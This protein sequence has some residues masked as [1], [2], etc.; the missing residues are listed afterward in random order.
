[1]LKRSSLLVPAILVVQAALALWAGSGEYLPPAPD[2]DHFPAEFGGWK[3][4]AGNADLAYVIG[5]LHS[6]RTMGWTYAQASTNATA[7]LFSAWFQSQRN[8]AAQPHSPQVCLPGNG[9]TMDTPSEI[10][11]STPAGV[12]PITRLIASKGAQRSLVW[13]WYETARRSVAGEWE[14][15]LWLAADVWREKRSDIAIVRVVVP[16]SPGN[17]N[18]AT[19]TATEFTRAVYP[20][21]RRTLPH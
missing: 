10:R 3:R 7:H 5:L 14:S 21:M 19:K 16:M 18:E 20:L 1:M 15:K 6:D 13:Y 2:F 9:W 11:V 17:E 12:L 8:S 4:V